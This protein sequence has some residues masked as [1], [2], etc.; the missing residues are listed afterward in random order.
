MKTEP[1]SATGEAWQDRDGTW[2]LP[3]NPAK[4]LAT[5]CLPYASLSDLLSAWSIEITGQVARE[6]V[7]V[8]LTWRRVSM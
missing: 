4:G 3:N 2:L 7:L 8:A 5:T 6:D 1:F